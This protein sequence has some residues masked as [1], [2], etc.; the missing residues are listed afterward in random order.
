MLCAA[1]E[2][3]FQDVYL[4]GALKSEHNEWRQSD[5]ES[6]QQARVNGCQICNFLWALLPGLTARQFPLRYAFELHNADFAR[7]GDK[8]EYLELQAGGVEL[9][10]FAEERAG[11]AFSRYGS[12]HSIHNLRYILKNRCETLLRGD[13]EMWAVLTFLPWTE[14][15]RLPLEIHKGLYV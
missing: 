2:S 11:R 12:D 7:F 4:L 5:L 3:I 1:C 9:E 10:K 13:V 6:F 15:V 14:R 8:P